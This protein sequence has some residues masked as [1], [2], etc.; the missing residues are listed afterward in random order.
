MA[1]V[2]RGIAAQ[3]P[4][5]DGWFEGRRPHF[6]RQML[7]DSL[8]LIR[9]FQ[10]LYRL[11][12]N[13]YHQVEPDRPVFSGPAA[14]G[15]Q[16]ELLR[17]FTAM[18]GTEKNNGPLWQLKDL[19]HQIWPREK[20]EPQNHGL[21]IDWLIGSLFHEAMKLKENLYLLNNYG[22]TAV[23]IDCLAEHVRIRGKQFPDI[24]Q[25]ADIGLLVGRIAEDATR[26]MERIGF[27]FGQMNYL[28]RL[29]LPELIDNRLVIRLLAEREKVV[30][31][32]WGES[33]ETLFNS[34]FSGGVCAGFCFAGESFLRG[35][36]YQQALEMYERALSCDR[37]CNEAWIRVAHLKAILQE[38][39]EE[40][41]RIKKIT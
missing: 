5:D 34:L 12:L 22:T 31:E 28:I 1:S 21:L 33:L 4:A 25:R 13:G 8:D 6:V 26:Q 36:W 23:T 41:Q 11:Y 2:N 38:D 18:L 9:W 17:Q 15:V 24:L 14:A 35:Q 27:L 29:M 32:L 39:P 40:A 20:T 19:C 37:H 10:E 3:T 7:S 16:A 30:A